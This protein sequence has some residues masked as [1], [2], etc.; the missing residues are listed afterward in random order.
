MAL[1]MASPTKHRKTG[2]FYSRKRV[3][4]DLV[5]ALGKREHK[6][7]LGTRDPAVAKELHSQKLIEF[8]RLE[9]MARARPEPLYQKTIVGL[10]G[11]AYR[12]LITATDAEPGETEIWD[13]LLERIDHE[14][15]SGNLESWYG[16]TADNILANHELKADDASRKG[17]L[18]EIHKAVRQGAEVSRRKAEGDYSKDPKAERFP[19][20]VTKDKAAKVAGP[21]ITEF[22]ELWRRR[23]L[24]NAKAAG[25]PDD[26][27]HKVTRFIEF[28]GH[29]RARDVTPKDVAD[30]CD[31]LQFE[32]G[33]GAS[34]VR[35]KYL[36][37]LKAVFKAGKRKF[38][39]E[40]SPAHGVD[41]DVTKKPRER[42]LGFTDDEAARILRAALGAEDDPSRA[43][44]LNKSACRWVPWICAYTGARGGEIT[45]LRGVDFIKEN[46]IPCVRIT[47]EDDGATVK[48]GQYRTV[49]LHPHLVEQG[50][51]DFVRSRGDGPI[52]Y[53]PNNGKRKPGSTQAGNVRGKVSEWVRKTAKVTD[54]RVQPNHAWR[55]RF[56][57][58]ARDVDMAHEYQYAILGHSDGRAA[59]DYGENTMKALAREIQKLPRYLDV[60]DAGKT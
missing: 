8:A 50:L 57:T 27:L 19:K 23:H 43:A 12:Q 14:A 13:V 28:L 15:S 55:H 44:A 35:G 10:A 21:T 7:S 5:E 38:L 45:Q 49:P 37:A 29:E 51:L 26:H 48:T 41:I 52:F 60:E 42:P 47:S 34:T 32:E 20:L 33:I 40:I 36:S 4:A 30:F 53:E 9:R 22:F 24:D 46:G 25:T 39:I 3:P 11:E 6:V 2:I 59:S 31:H 16:P 17:L 54:R 56:K 58:I 1:R 18:V